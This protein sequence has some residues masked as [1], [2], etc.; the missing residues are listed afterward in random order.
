MS[1]NKVTCRLQQHYTYRLCKVLCEVGFDKQCSL[2]N[3]FT[4][5]L[6]LHDC[7]VY[8]LQLYGSYY[9]RLSKK[10]QTELAEANGVAEEVLSAMTTVRAHAAQDSAESAYSNKLHG[11]YVLQKKE[12]IAYAAYSAT[13]TFLPS[14]V[15]LAV[16][17]YGGSLVLAG[18]MSPGSLVSFMLYQQS[19]SSA[20]Q[21]MG[22]VFS[23]LT[24]AVGAADKVI[25]L[26]KREP[27]IP[28]SGHHIP[29]RFEGRLMLES[30]VFSYPARPQQRV[31]NGLSL[32]INPGE[33]LLMSAVFLS[34]DQ[35]RCCFTVH[36]GVYLYDAPGA[37]LFE[38]D[39]SSVG[40]WCI[41]CFAGTTYHSPQRFHAR[42]LCSFSVAQPGE[43]VALVGPS[44]G[45]KSSIIKLIQRF[46]TPQSGYVL[47]D[48]RDVGVYDAK[49]LRRHVALVSQEPVLFARSIKRNICYGLEAEDGVEATPTQVSALQCTA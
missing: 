16:L 7:P 49:W 45:G 28:P 27:H 13:S 31:L 48:G 44:G 11:F 20:F 6:M 43:V 30:V 2:A 33:C 8:L 12:A 21:M 24:A 36:I 29:E 22:D 3:L 19:L 35:E 4:A 42:P 37:Y 38:I 41:H 9:R 34:R 18:Q 32:T 15:A 46:Y 39:F 17:Y 23:A 1:C 26:M 40:W 10:V 14:T 25:E 5:V 47:V